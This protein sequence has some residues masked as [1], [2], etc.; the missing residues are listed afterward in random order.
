MKLYAVLHEVRP[1]TWI[2]N[3]LSPFVSPILIKRSQSSSKFVSDYTQYGSFKNSEKLVIFA[4][5]EQR[6]ERIAN[7]QYS[8]NEYLRT[9]DVIF[10]NRLSKYILKFCVPVTLV[11][12]SGILKSNIR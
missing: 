8:A 6:P 11:F 1:T 3:L 9:I 2:Q 10:E 4:D 5:V 7:I 12:K